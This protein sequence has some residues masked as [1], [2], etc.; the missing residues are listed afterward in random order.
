VVEQDD[1]ESVRYSHTWTVTNAGPKRSHSVTFALGCEDNRG[2]GGE[3]SCGLWDV[4]VPVPPLAPGESFPISSAG[5]GWDPV[6][7]I[8]RVQSPAEPEELVLEPHWLRFTATVDPDGANLDVDR[9]NNA[10]EY[11]LAN[12]PRHPGLIEAAT[13]KATDVRDAIDEAGQG[14]LGDM[15][16]RWKTRRYEIATE[17]PWVPGT[18]VWILVQNVSDRRAPESTVRVD[19]VDLN[20]AEYNRGVEEWLEH[21]DPDDHWLP[22]ETI[23]ERCEFPLPHSLSVPPLDPGEF[24]ALYQLSAPPVDP[25]P[26]PSAN[27]LENLPDPN[28]GGPPEFHTNRYAITF[29][30]P[31]AGEV[32]RLSTEPE[33]VGK[34]P[35][36]RP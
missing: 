9:A 26:D 11:V 36:K 15:A 23:S 18:P 13:E 33:F 29:Q 20:K 8:D 35:P 32:L 12:M 4:A 25:E 5:Q 17:D 22:P 31:A 10:A 7:T 30:G 3:V 34:L 21:E 6:A 16:T 28:P 1:G 14:R 24:H 27:P 19:C 2:E